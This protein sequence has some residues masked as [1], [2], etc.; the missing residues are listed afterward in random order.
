MA[1]PNEQRI[2]IRDC[3][4]DSIVVAAMR[5]QPDQ[6]WASFARLHPNSEDHGTHPQ[7]LNKERLHR[8]AR[9]S[10]GTNNIRIIRERVRGMRWRQWRLRFNDTRTDGEFLGA[11]SG[12]HH[13]FWSGRDP[14]MDVGL[15][16]LMIVTGGNRASG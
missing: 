16:H 10:V 3:T 2:V 1:A 9:S 6:S 8:Y 13:Q 7:S 5:R 14:N 12:S 15:R 4:A 11:G